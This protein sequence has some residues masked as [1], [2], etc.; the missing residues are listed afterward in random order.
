M[1][2]HLIGS[3]PHMLESMLSIMSDIKG[4]PI[5]SIETIAQVTIPFRANSVMFQCQ[6]D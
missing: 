1:K 2:V 3:T 5:N 4:G 6:I